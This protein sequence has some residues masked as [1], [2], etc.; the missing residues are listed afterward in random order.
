MQP[1]KLHAILFSALTG[2]AYERRR[3]I[4]CTG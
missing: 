3:I 2:A 1:H 4:T